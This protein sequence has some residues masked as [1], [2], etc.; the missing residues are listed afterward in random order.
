MNFTLISPETKAEA[1]IILPCTEEEITK[2]CLKLEVKNTS[3]TEVLISKIK[4]QE[5]DKDLFLLLGRKTCCLEELNFLM[6]A[7][8]AMK[9]TDKELFF[10]ASGENTSEDLPYL[11]NLLYNLHCFSVISDFACLHLMGRALHLSQEEASEE[12][13]DNTAFFLQSIQDGKFKITEKGVV[14]VDKSQWKDRYVN[15][16]FPYLQ[17]KHAPLSLKI[18]NKD[19]CEYLNLP[20]TETALFKVF[21]RMGVSSLSDCS[22]EL[23]GLSLFEGMESILIEEFTFKNCSKLALALSKLRK[24]ERE[25]VEELIH[26]TKISSFSDLL[27]LISCLDHFSVLPKVSTP[28]EYGKYLVSRMNRV[29]FDEKLTVYVDFASYG[30]QIATEERG[31]FTECGYLKY[32]GYNK[33]MAEILGENLGY[34]ARTGE[35]TGEMKLFMP[36]HY[37]FHSGHEVDDLSELYAP[38]QEKLVEYQESMGEIRGFMGLY[39]S[40]DAI[41]AKVEKYHFDVEFVES[42][43]YGVVVLD[44]N[45]QL[46]EEECLRMK[47]VIGGQAAGCISEMLKPEVFE[48]E[49][50][51]VEVFLWNSSHW[52]LKTKEE[53]MDYLGKYEKG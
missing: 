47:Q 16:N 17:E 10:M 14:F 15:G 18:F 2:L 44:L 3:K 6:K 24:D 12:N 20:T 38:L 30:Q 51:K 19:S 9:S 26:F 21:E 5:G 46:T 53:L 36:I 1:E 28:E 35:K 32:D 13:F 7:L 50:E 49:G 29:K 4:N 48:V 25:Q 40:R 8:S 37:R 34:V 33:K 22:M 43:L 41:H 42:D 31:I 11:I 52:Y 27:L 45:D 23:R 39:P